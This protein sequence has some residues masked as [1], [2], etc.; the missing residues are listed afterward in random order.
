MPVTVAT[1]AQRL[2]D[3]HGVSVSESSVRRWISANPFRGCGSK[4]RSPC[5]VDAVEPGSEAQI[6]YGRLGMWLRPGHRGDGSR[7]GCS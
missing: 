1:V 5:R 3:D 7:C 6:D 4:A 2:R